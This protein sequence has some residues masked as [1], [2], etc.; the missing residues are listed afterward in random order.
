MNATSE[1][2]TGTSR[3]AEQ[4]TFMVVG[5]LHQFLSTP[6]QINDQISVMRVTIPSGVVIPLHSHADPEIFYVLNGSL[7]VFQA[8]G[9]S[10]G[11]QT[12]NAGEVASIPGNVKHAL[13]NTSPS[14][15]TSIIVTKQELYSFFRELARPFDPNSPPAPPTPEEMQQL[16][17]LAEKY[18]Y[19][20]GSPDE[21]A[22][23]G[24]SL[25]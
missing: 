18:G 20:L 21:N 5:V 22:A 16:F 17:S 19:W 11:W 23:I 14:P 25:R 8:E 10:E 7:E 1:T 24:I 3:G 13:R 9:P 15:I 12:V 2:K 6:E 4:Q